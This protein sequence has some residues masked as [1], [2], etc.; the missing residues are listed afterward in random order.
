[1][2]ARASFQTKARAI[3]HLGRGQIADAPTAVSELWKN[4]YDAYARKVELHI[5]GGEVPI[6][7]VIDNGH[8]MSSEEL[9]SNWLVIGTESKLT[10]T[11]SDADRF[12]LPDRRRQGEKGIGRL[13]AAFLAPMTLVVTKRMGHPFAALL[14]DWR[15][16]EN[17]FL[18]IGDINF[19]LVEFGDI[20]ELSGQLPEMFA[21]LQANL[22][23]SDTDSVTARRIA[24]A[25]EAFDDLESSQGLATT[26]RQ[27]IS[28]FLPGEI[29]SWDH[30]HP[31]WGMMKEASKTDGDLHGTAMFAVQAKPDL[32]E[33]VEATEYDGEDSTDARKN[34]R[35]T[36]INFTDPITMDVSPLEYAAIAHSADR[37][38]HAIVSSGDVFSIDE[39]RALEHYIEG[40]FD[41][42]GVFRGSVKAFGKERG[43]TVIQPRA[44]TQLVG[45]DRL[46]PF[47][48]CIGTIEVKQ[49]NTTHS[50][51]EYAYVVEMMDKYAGVCMYRDGLRVMPYGREGADL[52][53]IEQR[54]S[55]HAGREFFSYRR[56]FG[57][58]SF[59]SFENPNLKDKA[60]REGLV[61]NK[62]R[63]ELI[64]LVVNFLMD[65]ART[66][67][68]TDA[69]LRDAELPF[70]RKL[71]E[72]QRKSAETAKKR[73]Q[74][75]FKKYLKDNTPL[76]V[77]ANAQAK[78]VIV[79][80]EE[81]RSSSSTEALTNVK[82]EIDRLDGLRDDLRLPIR[83]S[84]MDE[85]EEAYRAYRDAYVE[86]CSILER[87]K[88]DIAKCEAMGLMGDPKA[89][90]TSKFHSNESRLSNQVSKALSTIEGHLNALKQT[91]TEAARE[92]RKRYRVGAI[93][94]LQQIQGAGLAPVLNRL[95]IA[96]AELREEIE[97]KYA[98]IINSLDQL[99]SGVDLE[100]AFEH[101]DKENTRLEEK[102]RQLNSVAQL[103][104][105]V[106]I[107][108]HELEALESQVTGYLRRMPT[109]VRELN[110]Y[111]LAYEAHRA[112]VDRLRFL[113]PLK[114]TAYRSRV[115]ITGQEIGK[116]ILDFFGD[117]FEK[118]RIDFQVSD[119]FNAI[120][121]RDLPSRILPSFINLVNNAL[122]WVQFG[123][124]R[125]I[126][127]DCVDG[128]AIV[129]DS[130]RGVD[131]DDV[132]RLF[133][134]FFTKRS[135]GRGLGLYLCR[136][137][138]AV[139][140]HKIW[141]ATE[142]DPK[143]LE[144]A[145]F[146]IEFSGAD[147]V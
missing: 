127:L 105:S 45:R 130:G 40:E 131:P 44:R 56:C 93:D 134:L 8:G 31:W 77:D 129:A 125:I 60:G 18:F 114:K 86:F 94:F 137:N 6:S 30:L 116:Y 69:P 12:G 66:Y 7:S 65:V 53:G 9:T 23:G 76:V 52:F 136:Q 107:I 27:S 99:V 71:N 138:L 88:M 113:T 120:R 35:D 139:A 98:P 16:F 13:S 28:S 14:V 101:T 10:S 15:F 29:I 80:L 87:L 61:D 4:A 59:S 49:V 109:Q 102:V 74:R 36:L 1:M 115:P 32:T 42:R 82:C 50:D 119:G 5:Y 85:E 145:N 2:F 133:E 104:I 24:A 72:A 26:T 147:N 22:C 68:G 122:H 97:E 62:A 43:T 33:C 21:S 89:I 20:K 135:N 64:R 63:K 46:G 81:A 100:G 95:D 79:A 41:E 47:R 118:Y 19:P 143:I 128:K 106:E 103:G 91:W 90:A 38:Q 78:R 57:R 55:K 75:N 111:K 51:E 92:D 144:G 67:F 108:G 37:P 96:Y 34:L 73:K 140:H 25:W 110:S 132:E 48:F 11:P 124:R 70:I 84:S 126:R 58:V 54:R 17:P 142:D 146:I 141:Y 112:L 83:P 121:L 3:D 39:F 117:T 123:D